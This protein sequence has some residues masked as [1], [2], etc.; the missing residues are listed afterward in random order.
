MRWPAAGTISSVARYY[1]VLLR[2]CARHSRLDEGLK[3]HGAAITTGLLFVPITFLPNVVLHM[4]AACGDLVSARKLFDDI[5]LT[6]KDTIDW[7]TL[8]SCYSLVG[9][10]LDALNLFVIM[11]REMILIDEIT[12]V[13]V[14]CACAKV[15]NRV[16]GIQGHVCMVKMGLGFSVK[17]CNAAMDMYVK[18]DLAGDARRMFDEMTERSIVSWTV[19]LGGVVKW[20]G[21]KEGR[22]LFDQMPEKNEIAWT[23]M[24]A[25]Y[26]ENCYSEEAFRLL[27]EMLF[28]YGLKLHFAALCSLLSACTQSGDVVMG[29]WLHTHALK[30]MAGTVIDV[31]VGTALLD[32]YAKCGRINMAIRVFG[33]MHSRTLVSWNAMLSGL[34]MHGKGAA[35]LDMFNQML[36]EVK[37]DDITVTAV[38]SACSHSGL[39]DQGRK[40]FCSLE[41]VYGISPSMENYA[42]MV[43]LLGRAGHLEEA[44]AVIRGM[45]MSPNEV[46]LGSLLGACGVH[47]K[48]VLGERLLRELVQL[49]PHNTEYHILL[50]NVYA[51][52]GKL[53]KAG[54]FRRVLRDRGI[55]KI[56][57]VSSMYVNG[58]VHHFTAGDKAHPRIKEIYSKLDEMIKRLRLSGYVP[59]TNSQIFSAS[60]IGMDYTYQQEE[61]ERVL[62]F[63]SEKLAVCFGLMSTKVGMPLYIFKNL[64]TCPDC[65]SAIKIASKVYGREI[66][67]RDRNRFHYF[68]HGSCSCADYW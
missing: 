55:R 58:Q 37:P 7:T 23:I 3:I 19:L 21:L 67:I 50:S 66:I 40:I 48:Q 12:L 61:K 52:S 36:E 20:M 11:R 63:H 2:S 47:R 60:D 68:K 9:S 29:K 59:D 44:E 53:D 54:S 25:A 51:L 17:A 28:S 26:V 8:M 38:L 49:Y 14:F 57:G 16:F 13:S 6:H 33:S 15:G 41:H 42:C 27:S 46:V 39:V 24:T 56:P 10:H 45:P 35:V 22:N 31:S 62:Q 5:P 34:A 1:R 32:M 4:Y 30:T 43:D 65:H 64:R 18:C